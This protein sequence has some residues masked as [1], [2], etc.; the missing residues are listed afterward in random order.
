MFSIHCVANLSEFQSFHP[1][2][3]P[4]IHAYIYVYNKNKKKKNTKNFQKLKR[5]LKISIK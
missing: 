2:G 3:A 5:Q 1:T 4:S